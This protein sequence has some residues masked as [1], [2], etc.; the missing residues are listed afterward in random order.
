MPELLSLKQLKAMK[1]PLQIPFELDVPGRE[2]LVCEEVF[3]IFQ[4]SV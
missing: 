1:D 4:E 3:D 2:R